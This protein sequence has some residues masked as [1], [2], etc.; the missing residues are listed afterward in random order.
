MGTKSASAIE[1]LAEQVRQ[2]YRPSRDEAYDAMVEAHKCETL[3]LAIGCSICIAKGNRD[4][5]KDQLA[6]IAEGREPGDR[7]ELSAVAKPSN[8]KDIIGS[9]KLPL[10]LAPATAVAMMTVG[11]LNGLCKYGRDNFRAIGIRAS[12][13]LDAAERH[14][15]AWAEGEECDPD[16]GVPHLAAALSCL[17]IIVDARAAGKMTDDRRVQGGYHSLVKELTPHVARLKE[18]HKD[19]SPKHYSIAD[20]DSL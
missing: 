19:K 7:I 2:G 4:M 20:N 11:M 14:M 6:R 5:A 15:K 13:Y 10:S 8:P 18:L 17:A 12:I 9:G 16:D 3:D 1:E